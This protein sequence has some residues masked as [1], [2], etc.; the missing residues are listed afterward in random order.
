MADRSPAVVAASMFLIVF[1]PTVLGEIWR[2]GC[3]EGVNSLS[4][5]S[6]W[7][8]GRS[9]TAG[10]LEMFLQSPTKEKNR[11]NKA[12][13]PPGRQLPSDRADYTGRRTTGP[14]HAGPGW[15]R[16][17]EHGGRQ[18]HQ[19]EAVVQRAISCWGVFIL[20][21][22]FSYCEASGWRCRS[23]PL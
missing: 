17:P 2:G 12:L 20:N 22:L 21:S 5:E 1:P 7:A 18:L 10:D 13:I 15:T 16:L 4:E 14:S 8:A 19:E 9:V 6:V 3:R 11:D 23:G